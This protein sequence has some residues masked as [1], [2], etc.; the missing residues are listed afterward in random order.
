LATCAISFKA[1][2]PTRLA[3]SARVDRSASVNRSLDDRRARRIA[4]LG[5]QIFV[6]Q[7]QL[8]VDEARHKGQKAC[9]MESIA[10]DRKFMIAASTCSVGVREPPH[11]AGILTIRDLSWGLLYDADDERA[12]GQ[13]RSRWRSGL[14]VGRIATMV[15]RTSNDSRKL[16]F[17]KNA[18]GPNARVSI[19][20]AT[21][22]GRPGEAEC[23]HVTLC[24]MAVG[25]HS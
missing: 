11:R 24:Y 6:A 17:D 22:F 14:P 4:I 10:H 9:P 18:C 3:I 21:G 25:R 15:Q 5:H 8:L 2:R 12:V 19:S 23:G 13:A 20:I 16:W 1:L 7:Q